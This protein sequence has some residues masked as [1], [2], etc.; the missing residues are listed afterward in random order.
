MFRKR[1][2]KKK[3]STRRRNLDD[4]EEENDLETSD[5]LQE[6]REMNNAKKQKIVHTVENDDDG[7]SSPIQQYRPSNEASL[8][9]KDLAT[10]TSHHHPDEENIEEETV[11]KGADGIFRDKT[12][13]KFYAGPIKTAKF[14]RTTARFDYQPD[15]CKDYKDT[16]FCGFGDTCIY[17]HDRGDSMTGWQLEQQYEEQ[18][19]K[20]RTKQ[21][22]E[23]FADGR[24]IEEENTELL[25]GDD[26][27]PFA[28]F[29]CRD[30]FQNP[31]ATNCG[32]YFCEKCILSHV[33]KNEK[34]LCPICQKDTHGVF[35]QPI[36]LLSKKRRL[37]GSSATWEEFKE[38][39]R[40]ESETK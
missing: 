23:A 30:S 17:L 2:S 4:N 3:N 6:A 7:R 32:H 26:G 36:K 5:L 28:C 29:L 22:L 15:I 31:V 38:A 11:G 8:S 12:R 20:E 19:K 33:R 34:S 27:L 14:M 9:E 13:N 1:K 18:K 40:K 35:N 39:K 16:G 25:S 10:K 24:K 37:L 21:E